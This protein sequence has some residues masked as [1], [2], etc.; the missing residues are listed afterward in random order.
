MKSI[1]LLLSAALVA[2]ISL[3][4]IADETGTG[5]TRDGFSTSMTTLAAPPDE[6]GTGSE[7]PS[8][9][10]LSTSA[11]ECAMLDSLLGLCR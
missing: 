4:A 7:S 5:F 9:T 6:T 10:T 8:T 1:T 11:E 3:S 2:G